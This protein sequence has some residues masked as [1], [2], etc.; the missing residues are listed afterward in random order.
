MTDDDLNKEDAGRPQDDDDWATRRLCDDGHC[1]GVI[2]PDGRCKECGRPAADSSAP[3]PN[4]AAESDSFPTD[5]TDEASWSPDAD[6]PL[7]NE[8]DS[9]P[10]DWATRRLCSDGN[11]IGVIGPDGRCK[12]CGRPAE[13]V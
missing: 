6:E 7:V 11:C 1:I 3:A 2:G 4:A 10:D 12:E 8:T 5:A 13:D 9:A